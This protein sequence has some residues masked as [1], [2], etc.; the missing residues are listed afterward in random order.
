MWA[1]CLL[2]LTAAF[3]TVDHELL[4]CRLERQFGLR[5]VV[6]EW[7]RSYLSGRT[8]RVVFSGGTSSIIYVVCSVPQGSVLGPLLFIVY[9]ADRAAIA[10]K[11]DVSLQAFADDTQLYLHCRRTDTASV[12]ARLEQCITDVG[13]WMCA[14]RLK[15]NADKTELMWIETQSFSARRLSSSFTT[16]FRL[17]SSSW[18]RPF[19][20]SNAVV[21][22]ELRPTCLRRQRVQFLLVTS[23]PT[24]SAFTWHRICDHTR[25]FVRRVAHWLLQRSLGGRAESDDQQTATSVERRSPCGQRYP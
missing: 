24:I 21:R 12:A 17:H 1:L 7:F 22:F 6:L 13:R 15:L 10:E 4:I 2:D 9:T 8:F 18:P 20:G 11:H 25:T 16:R 5:G 19:A 23:T 3:D 14:N